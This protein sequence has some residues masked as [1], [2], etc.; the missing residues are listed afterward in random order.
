MAN[1]FYKTSTALGIVN[2][3]LF[4]LYRSLN[5]FIVNHVR[6]LLLQAGGVLHY[7]ITRDRLKGWLMFA[8]KKR[9]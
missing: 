4:N 1:N 6:T 5:N 7:H 9:G 8:C 3:I 2:M